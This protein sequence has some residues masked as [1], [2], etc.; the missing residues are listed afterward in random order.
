MSHIVII[1]G[2]PGAGKSTVA[3]SLCAR[4]DRTV[5]LKT[6]ELYAS[7]RMGFIS[8]WKPESDRQ[9]HMI[10]RAA[11][12]AA[13]AFA[14]ELYAVFIDGVIGPHLLPEYLEDLRAAAVPVHFVLLRPSLDE[15]VRRGLTRVGAE[16]APASMRVP[17]PL[18]RRGHATFERW[19]DFA[20]LT[21]DNSEL[22]ADQTADRVMDA[23]GAGECLVL[24]P[25][26]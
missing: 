3:E 7:V 16:T 2:P 13:T 20:G 12:R 4:Y 5:H 15:I 19:G 23:C 25:E 17:E 6:D 1:S 11:A 8:P 10:S 9:N 24:A 22:T 18:L 21:I 26:R 14:Q